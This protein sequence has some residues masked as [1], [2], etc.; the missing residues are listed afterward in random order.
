MNRDM[1]MNKLGKGLRFLSWLALALLLFQSL[2]VLMYLTNVRPG[3]SGIPT[4]VTILGAVSVLACL[5]RSSLWVMIYRK[6]AGAVS[7]LGSDGDD[8]EPVELTEIL[9]RLARLLVASCILD[10][11]LLPAIF[12]MDVFFPFSL[13]SVQ[14]GLIQL[15]SMLLPQAFGLS[16]LILAYLAHQ[17]GR[18]IGE[19]CRMKH[20]LDLTI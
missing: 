2:G 11:L 5:V 20:E 12:L 7:A 18:L 6:G 4:G 1:L 16:A 14:L 3:M 17:Y 13:S 15:A 19:R 10:V 8:A 9:G